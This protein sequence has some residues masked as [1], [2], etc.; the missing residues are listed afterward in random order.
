MAGKPGMMRKRHQDDVRAKIGASQIVNRLQKHVNGELELSATQI[1]S[2]RILLDKSLPNLQS[3]EVSGDMALE[4]VIR[5]L[6]KK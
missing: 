1:Q 3:T 2:A 5:D 4:V 6:S